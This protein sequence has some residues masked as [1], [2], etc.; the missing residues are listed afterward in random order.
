MTAPRIYM[1]AGPNGAGKT[2]F[3][4]ELLPNEAACPAF[5]NADLI[6]AG[7]SPF[8]PAKAALRAG[9]I[10]LDLI[11]DHVRRGE[12][13][14]LETTLSDKSYA[15]AIPHWHAAGY[16]VALHFLSLPSAD[17][18]VARV[19]ARVQQGGHA[20][21]DD[22]IRRRYA[23][24][25]TNFHDVYKSLVDSWTLYDSSQTQPLVLDHGERS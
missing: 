7:L 22:V 13:F 23:S 11:K 2:T 12:S 6:A 14:A 24:G 8:D 25:L 19:A 3:A 17:T 20:I 10:M 15:R 16:F 1:L 21:P 18:A 9:R 4:R 5:I